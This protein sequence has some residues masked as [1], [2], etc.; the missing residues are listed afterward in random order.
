MSEGP[1]KKPTSDVTAWIDALSREAEAL[2][3]DVHAAV[4]RLRAGLARVRD[5]VD[6]LAS[7]A[8]P[9]GLVG[10]H[11]PGADIDGARLTAL[12]LVLQDTPRSEAR[13]LIAEQFPG[14][15]AG[16]LLDEIDAGS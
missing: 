7:A 12:D 9:S 13:S 14:V 10:A 2:E 3:G 16:L 11:E 6:A 15:D 5:E 1:E 8:A 4:Q